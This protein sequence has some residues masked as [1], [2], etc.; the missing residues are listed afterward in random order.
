MSCNLTLFSLIII[1]VSIFIFVLKRPES[2]FIMSL[3]FPLVSLPLVALVPESLQYITLGAQLVCLTTSIRIVNHTGA[4]EKFRVVVPVFVL[5][6]LLILYGAI[7]GNLQTSVTLKLLAAK[8]IL[9][10]VVLSI[11]AILGL[12]FI[13]KLIK[14]LFLVVLLNVIASLI[15]IVLG[16]DRLVSLGLKYG[17]NV[18]SLG[19]GRLRAPGLSL[20]NFD[21][22]LLCGLAIILSLL[23]LE[24]YFEFQKTFSKVLVTFV[25][26][27]SFIGIFV[28]STR[29]GL[30]FAS[31]T[32]LAFY[33]FG[34]S[35]IGRIMIFAS[36]ASLIIFLINL[37]FPEFL[38]RQSLGQRFLVWQNILNGRS[39]IYGDGLG[40]AGSVT[41]SSFASAGSRLVADNYYLNLLIQ[42]GVPGIFF[43]I[44]GMAIYWSFAG[45]L[46]RSL[47]IGLAF[48]AAITEIW[49][50]TSLMT[51][52]L[53]LITFDGISRKRKLSREAN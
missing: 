12:Q 23:C 14:A 32:M 5:F 47:I 38:G 27:S 37:L 18:S 49:E 22:S 50:Y 28:S 41:N 1:A 31:V 11:T 10:P 45:Q 40:T 16:V 7:F 24:N 46:G 39:L 20:T 25:L 36:F 29:S 8:I 6:F 26:V 53:I 42:F 13:R 51:M 2:A 48:T 44:L 43:F 19:S 33:A 15:Q 30:L 21:F 4:W 52:V 35:N 17:S 9:L 34:K 3:F